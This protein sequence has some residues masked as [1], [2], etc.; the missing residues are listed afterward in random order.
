MSQI[1]IHTDSVEQISGL[2]R[3]NTEKLSTAKTS[4]QSTTHQIDSRILARNNISGRLQ[5]AQS[6]LGKITK[7]MHELESF[8]KR[9]ANYYD[10]AENKIIGATDWAQLARDSLM[11]AAAMAVD[12]IKE[13]RAGKGLSFRLLRKDGKILIKIVRGKVSSHQE[14]SKFYRLLKENLGGTSKWSRG[15][16][17]KLVNEGVPIYDEVRG[18]YFNNRNKFVNT[19]FDD[20]NKVIQNVGKEDIKVLGR[21]VKDSFIDEVKIWDDFRGW[22]NA[23]SLATTGKALGIIGTG[24]MIWS[25]VEDSFHDKHTGKWNYDSGKLKDFSVNV[26]VDIGLGAGAVAATG[27]AFGSLF[28]PPVGTV[29]GGIVG[30]GASALINIKFGGPPAES[31]TDRVKEIAN[32]PIKT[33]KAIGSKISNSLKKIF[34]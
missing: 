29:V 30:I 16:V 15:F 19:Q 17:T 14:F 32:N 22:K 9:S 34:W 28:L 13:S 24:F 20:L 18:R 4:L 6:S 11:G 23:Q 33:A 8:L 27:A 2:V 26:G 1:K 5:A 7:Q 12:P 21:A 3:H 31:I 25:N 10:E